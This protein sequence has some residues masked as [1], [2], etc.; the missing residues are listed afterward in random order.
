ME[1]SV[2]KWNDHKP[3]IVEHM[4]ELL[5]TNIFTDC[6]LSANGRNIQAH[7]FVLAAASPHFLVSIYIHVSQLPDD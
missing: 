4:F 7:R 2:I 3:T 5:H 6:I 1:N